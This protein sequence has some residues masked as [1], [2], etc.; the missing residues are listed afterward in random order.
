MEAVLLST[1]P[2]F[3]RSREAG[4]S[5]SA[6]RLIKLKQN[7]DRPLS[8]ILTLNTIAHTVGAAGVGAQV[9]KIFGDAYFGIASAVLTLLILVVSEIIPKTIGATYW[10]ELAMVSAHVIQMTIWITYPLVIIFPYITQCFSKKQDRQTVSIEEISLL[11]HIGTEEG[12]FSKKENVI[13][14]NLIRLKNIKIHE[15]MTPRVV[16]TMAEETMTLK[17]FLKNKKFL[18]FSRIP[19]YAGSHENVTGY[20]LRQTVFEKLAENREELRLKDIKREIV[21][22]PNMSNVFKV[23]EILLEKKEHIALVVDEYGGVDGIVTLEDIVETLLG[24]EILDEK[25]T[26]TDMQQY[27]R[28]RWN[29]RKTKYMMLE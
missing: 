27:A 19:V 1:T 14:Q 29:M 28:E 9:T 23:W 22:V 4:G 18:H 10:K 24:I 20:V 2:S 26:I 15:I 6:K 7:I 25:D 16:V 11:A 3:L 5:R 13:L 12:I 21:V 8:A 17:D